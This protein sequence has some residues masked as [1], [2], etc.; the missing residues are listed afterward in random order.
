MCDIFK[1]WEI[2]KLVL[3]NKK[4]PIKRVHYTYIKIIMNYYDNEIVY[5]KCIELKNYNK[6]R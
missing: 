4:M 2:N 6:F 3:L 1:I 5:V